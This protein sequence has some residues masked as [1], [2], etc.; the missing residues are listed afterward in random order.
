[1]GIRKEGEYSKEDRNSC[2]MNQI[3]YKDPIAA[4]CPESQI[5]SGT[6][7][8]RP[9]EEGK[10]QVSQNRCLTRT[11][12]SPPARPLAHGHVGPATPSAEPPADPSCYLSPA[13]GPR[14]RLHTHTHTHTPQRNPHARAAAADAFASTRER[15]RERERGR[16]GRRGGRRR[17]DGRR[18]EA[19]H[20]RGRVRPPSF[21]PSP[22][23]RYFSLLSLCCLQPVCAFAYRRSACPPLVPERAHSISLAHGGGVFVR[24]ACSAGSRGDRNAGAVW[25][26]E[27]VQ[28]D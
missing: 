17:W 2:V 19:A 9:A 13:P 12:E 23:S 10:G 16:D 25:L 1:M 14:T 18:P 5:W 20:V 11:R 21:S 7:S 6:C 3:G 8:P 27:A 26:T 15:E 28:Y 4:V 24:G 22:S